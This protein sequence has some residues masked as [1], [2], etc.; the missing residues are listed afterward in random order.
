MKTLYIV[1]HAKSDWGNEGLKDIDRHLNNTGYNDAYLMS[2][3]FALNNPMPQLLVS[4]SAIRALS[5]ALI[6]AR[7]FHYSERNILIEERIYEASTNELISCIAELDNK[8]N[9]V[10]LFGHNP[11]LTNL[12]NQISD[13][14]IDNLPPCGILG[15][16]FEIN[17]WKDILKIKG[18]SFLTNF[19]K[20][21]RP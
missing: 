19:P 13:S 16:N 10:M 20:E 11:G 6:F 9:N 1:R 2:N 12:F 21:F 3:N 15:I 17:T 5:T 14:F 4:S 8:L 18:K 7:S